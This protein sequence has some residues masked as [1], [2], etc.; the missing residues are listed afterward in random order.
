MA[1][2]SVT[3]QLINNFVFRIESFGILLQNGQTMERYI[4]NL[5]Y[6]ELLEEWE[7][8]KNISILDRPSILSE[9]EV[10]DLI[11]DFIKL[12]ILV[13]PDLWVEKLIIFNMFLI[14]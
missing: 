3:F 8:K 5:K 7:T 6:K 2:H 1:N 13:Q 14:F 12:G 11:E 9:K 10:N 4:I